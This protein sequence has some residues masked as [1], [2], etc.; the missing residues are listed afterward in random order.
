LRCCGQDAGK[1]D[2]AKECRD[3]EKPNHAHRF[4]CFSEAA[5]ILEAGGGLKRKLS[6]QFNL[7]AYPVV[8]GAIIIL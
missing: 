3:D 6:T 4:L 1:G 8:S 7:K 5:L 2:A